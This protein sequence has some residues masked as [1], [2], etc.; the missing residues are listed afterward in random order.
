MTAPQE[1]ALAVISLK[2]I[3]KSFDGRAV[4]QEVNLSVAPAERV[5]LVGASGCGKSTLLSIAAGVLEPD[6]GDVMLCEGVRMAYLYQENRLLPWL[7]ALEN[8]TVT[9][10]SEDY[11]RAMLERV[12]LGADTHKKPKQLSG[13]MKRRLAIARALAYGGDIYY[14]DEPLQGLDDGTAGQI[15]RVMLEELTGKTA[16]IVSH[17]SAEIEALATRIINLDRADAAAFSGRSEVEC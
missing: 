9:G 8:I 10:V 5:C 14:L 11:A 13:G 2:N 12:G 7:T 17:S 15:L 4:L 3:Y 16:L 1:G 6:S